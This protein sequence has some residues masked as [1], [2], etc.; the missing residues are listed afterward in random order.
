[1]LDAGEVE[2]DSQTICGVDSEILSNK[3]E[4]KLRKFGFESF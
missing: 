3:T 1:M 2:V 4:G